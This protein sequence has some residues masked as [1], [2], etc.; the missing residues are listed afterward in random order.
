MLTRRTR[1]LENFFSEV[2]GCSPIAPGA[3]AVARRLRRSRQHSP[4]YP[5]SSTSAGQT[6][7][8]K[9]CPDTAMEQ[10]QAAHRRCLSTTRIHKLETGSKKQSK[11]ERYSPGPEPSRCAPTE[12]L[13]PA[14]LWASEKDTPFLRLA[15][16]A[17][18][19]PLTSAPIRKKSLVG[20]ADPLRLESVDRCEQVRHDLIDVFP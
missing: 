20:Y 9:N 15:D 1:R 16:G 3:Q 12:K 6:Q 7:E 14:A 13:S 10:P 2:T 8:P 4:Q 19:L 17:R 5:R 18:L 11:C